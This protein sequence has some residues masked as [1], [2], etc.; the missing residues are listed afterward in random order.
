MCWSVSQVYVNHFR[1]F[2]TF[3]LQ[4]MLDR[5]RTTR[6]S[7][8]HEDVS[9]KPMLSKRSP[10][11][12][13]SNLAWIKSPFCPRV[14]NFFPAET[15][16][17]FV[18]SSSNMTERP[19]AG[20]GGRGV[21]CWDDIGRG[22]RGHPQESPP[23]PAAPQPQ[24]LVDSTPCRTS[25]ATCS[26]RATRC[27]AAWVCSAADASTG[28]DTGS[29]S[30]RSWRYWQSRD[31]TRHA[32]VVA[33]DA[34]DGADSSDS[35]DDDSGSEWSQSGTSWFVRG[36]NMDRCAISCNYMWIGMFMFFL[37]RFA[38]DV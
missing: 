36:D 38:K 20:W 22:G 10:F 18:R 31:R 5:T 9:W 1:Y 14:T 27:S 37:F 16:L 7:C 28:A 17:T 12:S 35:S 11:S 19:A 25:W 21:T 13:I 26:W 34:D 24:G 32:A 4:V 8:F 30:R 6:V 23:V 33:E 15:C 2:L 3:G 29:C